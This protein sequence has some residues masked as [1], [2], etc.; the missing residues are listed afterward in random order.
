[1]LVGTRSIEVS[2][3]VSERLKADLLQAFALA[4]ILHRHLR[5]QRTF[6]ER[7]RAELTTLL[8]L[9]STD[10]RRERE[11]LQNALDKLELYS[12]PKIASPGAAGRNSPARAKTRTCRPRWTTRSTRCTIKCK[13]AVEL[14]SGDARRLAEIICFQRLEDV[15]IE[16]M[17]KLTEACGLSG[18]AFDPGN[19]SEIGGDHRPVLRP[20]PARRVAAARHRRTMC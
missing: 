20:G 11:H 1:M 16:R 2:E 6:D 19:V 14:A 13:T 3:R 17:S 15:R 18:K 5:E 9:R 10:V 4:S 8:K 7:Q 12:Q